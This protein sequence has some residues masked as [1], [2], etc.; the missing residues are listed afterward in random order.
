MIPK[1]IRNAVSIFYDGDSVTLLTILGRHM[2]GS[3]NREAYFGDAD[4]NIMTTQEKVVEIK[5]RLLG[6]VQN[7]ADQVEELGQEEFERLKGEAMG[8]IFVLG[9]LDYYFEN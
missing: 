8:A 1:E 5:K 2:D 3:R 9:S 7:N 4:K 6:F